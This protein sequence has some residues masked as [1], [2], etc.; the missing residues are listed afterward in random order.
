VHDPEIA[1]LLAKLLDHTEPRGAKLASLVL[2]RTHIYLKFDRLLAELI[3]WAAEDEALRE[4]GLT[5]KTVELTG[6]KDELPKAV[7]DSRDRVEA[8]LEDRDEAAGRDPD[9]ASASDA[10]QV[11]QIGLTTLDGKWDEGPDWMRRGEFGP[12]GRLQL[13]S[14]E[15]QKAWTYPTYSTERASNYVAVNCG[16]VDGIDKW[17]NGVITHA[18]QGSRTFEVTLDSGPVKTA[19]GEFKVGASEANQQRATPRVRSRVRAG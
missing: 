4:R 15:E 5:L 16:Q 10:Q 9:A 13:P 7:T 17:E 2:I 14:L 3:K 18:D 1:A 6:D 8:I 19:G 11:E 12:G